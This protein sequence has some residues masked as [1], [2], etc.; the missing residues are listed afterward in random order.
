MAKVIKPHLQRDCSI[1]LGQA[2]IYSIKE[3]L[4][5]QKWLEGENS[6]CSRSVDRLPLSSFPKEKPLCE[7][8][9]SNSIGA[10]LGILIYIQIYIY[11]YVCVYIH[12]YTCSAIRSLAILC[13]TTHTNTV[14]LE[15][16]PPAILSL[17][18]WCL[19]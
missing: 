13:A 14:Q 19:N 6:A 9:I 12:I 16:L 4:Q 1:P 18:F 3:W 2:K 11:M 5:G 7:L 17:F 8:C 15:H 10:H